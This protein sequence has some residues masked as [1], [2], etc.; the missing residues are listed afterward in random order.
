MQA[1][2]KVL[3]IVAG[4][5]AVQAEAKQSFRPRGFMK[6]GYSDQVVK[7]DV[8]E[9]R[10]SAREHSESVGVA[11]YRAAQLVD[12]A[13]AREFRIVRQKVKTTTVTRRNTYDEISYH[14]VATL[15]VRVIR[16]E[17]D[18]SACD[19]PEADKCM[20]LSVASVMATYGPG[21]LMPG[22]KPGEAPAPIL[23][24]RVSSPQE[25]AMADFIARRQQMRAPQPP[26]A[27][28]AT[29]A[30]PVTPTAVIRTPG[31]VIPAA[32]VR[33]VAPR[34]AQPTVTAVGD[35]ATRLKAA[36]PVRQGDPKQGWKFV[37]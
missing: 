5:C 4:L 11:L 28:V 27:P 1:T 36:E 13:G 34:P 30:V 8:W 31:K 33:A 7:P 35:Y 6:T 15:T 37:D 18:R 21:L 22:N 17:Q 12:Q 9:I 29:P 26:T 10:S 25:R 32:A 23:A 24:I 20:T 2:M 3:A 19:M 16:T 14:E